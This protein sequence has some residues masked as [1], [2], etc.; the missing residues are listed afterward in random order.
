[1]KVS[2]EIVCDHTVKR[3]GQTITIITR[4]LFVLFH[5]NICAY[6][7]AEFVGFLWLFFASFQTNNPSDNF[8]KTNYYYYNII[9]CYFVTYCFYY[10]LFVLLIS[11]CEFHFSDLCLVYCTINCLISTCWSRLYCIG[12]CP[13]PKKN[14][15][16]SPLHLTLKSGLSRSSALSPHHSTGTAN[17][18]S[19]PQFG[20]WFRVVVTR[21]GWWT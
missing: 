7:V 13:P 20:C 21:S 10:S 14:K 12:S 19:N 16:T 17:K 18:W 4:V 9:Y 6:C 2:E 5:I 8:L 11:L 15:V 1:M 3:L